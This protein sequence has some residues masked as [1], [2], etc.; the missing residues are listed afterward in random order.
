MPE[1][2]RRSDGRVPVMLASTELASLLHAV[3]LAPIVER[4]RPGTIEKLLVA[5]RRAGGDRSEFEELRPRLTDGERRVAAA[6]A[7]A[8]ID[9][10]ELTWRE[11]LVRVRPTPTQSLAAITKRLRSR[12]LVELEDWNGTTYETVRLTAAGA[13]VVNALSLPWAVRT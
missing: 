8:A 10:G 13:D 9:P 12:G 7:L 4:P 5:L 11:L 1:L 2:P 3:R 6:L